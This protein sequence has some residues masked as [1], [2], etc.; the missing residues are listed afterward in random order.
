MHVS[1]V[2]QIMRQKDRLQ[3]V[4][5]VL[6]C[7]PKMSH[8]GRF[9]ADIQ[10]LR[11][12]SI[13]GVVLYHA[14]LPG[15]AGGFAGV[16][17]FFVISGF[18]ITGLLIREI[19]AKGA[20]DLIRF[21]ARRAARLL[22]NALTTLA[23]S[24][25]GVFWLLPVLA[26]ETVTKDLS[27]AILY[28][29]NY[30]F[31]GRS[32]DYFD[33]SVAQSPALHFWSLNV[34]EQFYFV[35]PIILAIGFLIFRKFD[36]RAICLFLI[37]L[38]TASL[39]TMII[40]SARVP[41]RAFFDTEARVWQL[42]VGALIAASG[43]EFRSPHLSVGITWLGLGGC[44]VSI[45]AWPVAI[46]C[47]SCR[48]L[49]ATFSA[50]AIIIGGCSASPNSASKALGNSALSWL[51][52]RSYSTYLWHWPLFTFLPYLVED[53]SVA[54][55][56]GLV[57]VIP[58]AHF[59]YNLVERPTRN[60]AFRFFSPRHIVGTA[61][62]GCGLA[63]GVAF[64]APAFDIAVSKERAAMVRRLQAAKADG[65]RTW[66][67]VCQPPSQPAEHACVFGRST[68]DRRVVLFGDSHAEHF[69]DGLNAAAIAEGWRLQLFTLGSC[70]PID[71]PFYAGPEKGFTPECPS[72]REGIIEHLVSSHPDLVIISSWTGLAT[73]MHDAI[74]GRR[75]SPEQSLKAWQS[76]FV[77]ILSRLRSAGI[78]TLVVRD[79]PGSLKAFGALCLEERA[80]SECKSPRAEVLL[81]HPDLDAA[82]RVPG[83]ETLDLSDRFC[84]AK[85]CPAFKDSVIV[86]RADNNHITATM[87]LTLQA[88][89]QRVL[90]LKPAR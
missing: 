63:A 15:F 36:R 41:P 40:Y 2:L 38:A 11:A 8:A 57:L 23:V 76:A 50:A 55:W 34:E 25:L 12:L 74:T 22:P 90:R 73:R 47:A 39:A 67:G 81:R 86:Y 42:A 80:P 20:I 17:I 87:S 37:L 21:W 45:L 9:R 44:I 71:A 83:V 54:G 49:L 53:E 69:F 35:W 32:L 68:A 29:A 82:N 1:L 62:L 52:D 13:L 88:D 6:G 5:R 78:R 24:L 65:P 64:A 59:A 28:F 10:G 85:F 70:P 33:T 58:V 43:L 77:A 3:P 75:Y 7:T 4:V 16:D 18:L 51:G 30:R 66:G 26:R 48:S 61:A 14:Q 79:V 46:H 56:L 19:R 60:N 84:D 72:W 27:S 31:S 89:F